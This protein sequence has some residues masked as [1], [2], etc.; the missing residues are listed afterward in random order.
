MK[1][2]C[3][4][5]VGFHEGSPAT[6]LGRQVGAALLFSLLTASCYAEDV[7]KLPEIRCNPANVLGSESC[8]KCHEKELSQ[9]KLTPH[10][11]TFELLHRKPEA[12]AIAKKLGLKSVKRNDLCV[13]CHYTRQL[14][15]ERVRI[16]SGISCESC[17]GAAKNWLA[18]H[19]DYGGP[20]ATKEDESAEHRQQRIEAS[21]AA[22]M[23]NPSN[24]YLVARQCL[25]CHT[26]PE[27]QLVNVGGHPAGSSEFELVS[28]SQGIVRHN[29]LRT[30]GTS[31]GTLSLEQL[32]VMYAVGVMADL[33]ASFRALA[34]ATTRATFGI[35]SAQRAARMKHKLYAIDQ[36]V[37]DPNIKRALAVALAEPLK[38]NR[39]EALS[40]AAD[41]IGQAAYRFAAE[42]DGESLVPL[43]PLLPS[44]EKYR[45]GNET[46]KQ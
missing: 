2:K 20:A 28:W 30:N 29:F 6:L 23:N 19:N 37:D 21:V 16:V 41:R 31:N 3:C 15:D 33:E 46:S 32:R 1:T 27:E 22:G 25:A 5:R 11:G 13:S 12:K 7:T 10:H 39:G 44:P 18:S 38:L 26:T 35:A 17:H 34:K 4:F 24:L 43:D 45:M 14:V 42:A 9:W 36:L 40:A 8:A